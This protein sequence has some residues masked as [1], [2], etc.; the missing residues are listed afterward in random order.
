MPAKRKKPKIPFKVFSSHNY[1]RLTSR[2]PFLKGPQIK[3]KLLQAWRNELDGKKQTIDQEHVPVCA[4]SE[5]PGQGEHPFHGFH[6]KPMQEL[7]CSCVSWKGFAK[8]R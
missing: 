5:I 4:S 2:F 8:P 3:A 1:S 6:I 7:K